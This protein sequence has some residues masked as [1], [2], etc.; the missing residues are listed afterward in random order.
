MSASRQP[1]PSD[2]E[3]GVWQGRRIA[4]RVV[5]PDGLTILVGKTARDNDI[6]SLKLAD[7]LDFW[8]HAAGMA[9]SHV[10][11]RNPDRLSRLPRET[12]RL[13]AGLAAGYSKARKGGKVDIHLAFC[14]AVS[15]ARGMPPG[16]VLLRRY[17]A[18]K[19][20]PLRLEDLDGAG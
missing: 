11:V 3:Q 19:A 20:A 7:P 15:K 18:V 9:G 8:M 16:K 5:S 13:A 6:L 1:P 10:V 12:E 4:R 17:K 14:D 2:P